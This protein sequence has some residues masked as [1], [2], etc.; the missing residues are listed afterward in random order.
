MKTAQAVLQTF[1]TPSL[2]N[3]CSLSS[4]HTAV[5]PPEVTVQ[6]CW[7][8]PAWLTPQVQ[9]HWTWAEAVQNSRGN[10]SPAQLNYEFIYTH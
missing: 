6:A 4:P 1:G 7:E 10:N 3:N 8:S 2:T 5:S 9:V